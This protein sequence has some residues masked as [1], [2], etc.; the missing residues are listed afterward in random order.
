MGG[1]EGLQ[2]V[3]GG[4]VNYNSSYTCMEEKRNEFVEDLCHHLDM[5]L[6]YPHCKSSS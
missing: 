3:E 4:N 2:D 1:E 6:C 5:A